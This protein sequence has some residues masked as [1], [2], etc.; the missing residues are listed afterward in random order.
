MKPEKMR[1]FKSRIRIIK[2]IVYAKRIFIV[3]EMSNGKKHLHELS[4]ITGADISHFQT[5]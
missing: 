3:V 5:D 4:Q 2:A 1:R